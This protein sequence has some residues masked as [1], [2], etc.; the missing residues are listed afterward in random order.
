LAPFGAGGGGG[1]GVPL[2]TVSAAPEEA[3]ET[4]ALELEA[5][6]STIFLP[7]AVIATVE[8]AMN[9]ADHATLRFSSP[10]NEL[11]VEFMS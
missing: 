3:A 5:G 9:I 2:A 10:R 7:Q 8:L 6:T 1:L 4:M 11:P